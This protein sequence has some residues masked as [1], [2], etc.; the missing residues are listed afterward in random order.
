MGYIN[1]W[2]NKTAKKNHY[3]GYS[4]YIVINY[5]CNFGNLEADTSLLFWNYDVVNKTR[6]I[7]Y[8]WKLVCV[9]VWWSLYVITWRRYITG[10]KMIIWN[11]FQ[12]FTENQRVLD[13]TLV[14]KCVVTSVTYPENKILIKKCQGGRSD[15]R[16]ICYIVCYLL[17][18]CVNQHNSNYIVIT[19]SMDDR[20]VYRST[21]VK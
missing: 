2:L 18:R 11:F 5:V 17:W 1:V 19:P 16:I 7:K 8:R 10:T 13:C 4:T 21:N 14:A 3:S 9:D 12:N 15:I 20:R 6:L